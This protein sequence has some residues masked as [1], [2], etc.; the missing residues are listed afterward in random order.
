MSWPGFISLLRVVAAGAPGHGPVHLLLSSAASLG[1]SLNPDL[2]V[3][4]PVCLLFVSFLVLFSFSA[5]LS[6]MLG[7]PRLLVALVLGLGFRGG[8]YLEFRGSFEA[9]ILASLERR[10][11][12][13][14]AWHFVRRCLEWISFRLCQRRNRSLSFFYG[15]PDGDGHSFWECPHLPFVHIRESPEFHDLLSVDRSAW[16]RCFLWHG[17]LPA[18]ACSGGASPWAA[19]VDDIAA[20]RLE[21][22]LALTVF[23][24]SG[25]LLIVFS[26]I[27]LPLTFQ[28]ILMCGLM[29]V[30][31]WM[32]CREE[33]VG[34]CGVYSLRSGAGWFGRR[35]GHLELLPPDGNFGLEPCVLFDSIRGPLQSV[36]RA[37]LWGVILPLQCSSSVHLGV[38][39]LNVVRHVSRI[40]VGHVSRKLFLSSLLMEFCSL[41]L[42]G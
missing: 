22:A 2:C 7:G 12:R 38:D 33:G 17:W 19:S 9:F 21:R 28:I 20:T 16:R 34:G 11:Q 39:N 4:Q 1:F 29:V 31:L 35:W 14:F 37:E 23:V 42:R 30:M 6:G 32:S 24:G 15:A 25:L 5:M 10:G 26:S 40:L 3:W 18:L 8:R 13:A 36:Q 27:W 41:S